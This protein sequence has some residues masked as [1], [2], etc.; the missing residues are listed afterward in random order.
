MDRN[1]D[2]ERVT[3]VDDI[4]FISSDEDEKPIVV[5]VCKMKKSILPNLSF[6]S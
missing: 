5:Q 1:L 4:D 3:S 2:E 6:F